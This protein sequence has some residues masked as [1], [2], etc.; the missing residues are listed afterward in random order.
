MTDPLSFTV[1]YQES[2]QGSKANFIKE[3]SVREVLT[4]IYK[5]KYR[6]DI[7]AL[8]ALLSNG[9]EKI[10]KEEKKKLPAITFA[11]T[12]HVNRN[13]NNLKS[14]T[15]LLVLDIDDLDNEDQ[16]VAMENLLRNDKYVVSCW[17]S[18]SNLGLKGIVYLE[19]KVDFPLEQAAYF[20]QSAFSEVKS[21]FYNTYKIVLDKSGK[22][23]VRT[24]FFSYD[25]K[26][27]YN[28]NFDR[29]PV[30]LIPT[31][32]VKSNKRKITSYADLT[33]E[34]DILNSPKN[35]N[36]SWHRKEISN[37]IRF[38][39]K[40]D[41]SITDAY[42]DWQIVA[43][44][45]ACC[46]TF[47]I[48]LKYFQMLSMQDTAKYD[49]RECERFLKARYLDTREEFSFAT[50]LYLANKIGY[51]DR[52][53]DP[54]RRKIKNIIKYLAKNRLSI[55]FSYYE[56]EKVGKAIV[57]TFD[58]DI[59]VKYFK[60]LSQ[61]DPGKYND[62]HCEVFLENLYLK[63]YEGYS[64]NTIIELAYKKGYKGSGEVPK[65]ASELSVGQV[66]S[67]NSVFESNNV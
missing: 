45:I 49:K 51:Q 67:I 24:C 20:H 54:N 41:L 42:N 34:A 50:I 1:F 28:R 32:K 10:Y 64:F 35:K 46:F 11:A 36:S 6:K 9:H 13:T 62:K 26:L 17:R 21:Y 61:Q 48:G 19:Y 15:G 16:V 58:Y 39:K 4:D 30:I 31:V 14:Y 37:I 60:L 25:S 59:G 33:V 38:L 47:N 7:E 63:N 22:D 55:T 8:R 12:F 5:G 65:M 56:W 2:V 43:R 23:I 53:V 29:F 44:T 3:I 57:Q 40:R 66:V 27:S 52:G 18:P